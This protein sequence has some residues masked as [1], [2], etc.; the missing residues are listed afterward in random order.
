MAL[1]PPTPRPAWTQSMLVVPSLLALDSRI[2]LVRER[3]KFSL[4]TT[5]YDGLTEQ[6]LHESVGPEM[7]LTHDRDLQ[8]ASEQSW[9]HLRKAFDDLS[10]FG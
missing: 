4:T 10:P 7:K 2:W 9:R 3:G 5:I 1:N 6:L 8:W